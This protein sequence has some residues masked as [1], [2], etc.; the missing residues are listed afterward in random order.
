MDKPKFNNKPNE[1]IQVGYWGEKGKLKLD[2]WVSR[3]I[4]VVGV[5][6]AKINGIDFVLV[7]KRSPHM[8]DEPNKFCLP[9]GYLDWN[10]TIV[11]AFI[12]E[13]YEETSLYLPDYAE[14][15]LND[16]TTPIRIYDNPNNNRQNISFVYMVSLNFGDNYD[17]FPSKIINYRNSETAEVKWVKLGELYNGGFEKYEWAFNHDNIIKSANTHR[18]EFI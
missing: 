13:V 17:T 14:Y 2:Y 12:R 5:I 1:H 11:D 4:A 18:L 10:E 9:C 8:M 15:I 6:F 3:S 7:S 16:I